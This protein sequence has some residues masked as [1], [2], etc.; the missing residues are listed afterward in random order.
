MAVVE[1]R[2]FKRQ[3]GKDK[4]TG[5]GR[6]T[7]DMQLAGMTHCKFLYAGIANGRI[8]RLDTSKAEALAGVFA[9]VTHAD[10]PDLH[11]GPYIQD[12][13]LFA[14][15]WVRFEGEIIAA[16]AATTPAVAQAA[17]DLIEVDIEPLPVMNDIEDSA[18]PDA[19]LVHPDWESYG[20]SYDIVR[21]R[22]DA[23]RSTLVFGDIDKG[24]A[25]ADTIISGRYVADMQHAAPIEPR[26]IIAEWHGDQVTIWS[27]TQVPFNARAGVAHTLEMPENAVRVIVPHLGGGFGGKCEFHFEAHVAAVARKAKRPTK[28]VFSRREEFIA[29]DHRREGMVITLETGVKR[30]G[31]ITGRRGTLLIDNGA[32]TA[33]GGFFPQLAA[34]HAAGPYRIPSCDIEARIVYTN[35]QPSGSV[36]APTAPQVNWALEQHMDVIAKSLGMDPLELRR[37]NIVQDGDATVSGQILDPHGAPLCLNTAAE[38]VGYGKD[39]PEDEAIGMAIGWWPSFGSSSG[40]YIK[41]NGDG[42]ATIVT[43]AM[44]CGSGAVMA[45]PRLAADVL[46]MQPENF[47]IVYQD[48]EAGPYDMGASGSQTTF[49]NGRAVVAAANV[50]KNRLFEMASERLEA[51]VGDLEVADGL[52]RVKGSPDKSVSIVDLAGEATGGDQLLATGSGDAPSAPEV[53]GSACVGRMGMESWVAPTFFCHAAHVKVDRETGV[54]RVLGI[55]AVHDSGTIINPLG[56]EGQIE[57]GVVMGIGQALLEGSKISDDG[58]ILNAGLLEYKLQTAADVPPIQV[59]FVGPPATDGGPSGVKGIAEPP[60]VPTLA[61]IGNAIAQ[62]IGTHVHELP[63]TPNRVWDT[64][65][66]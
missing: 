5:L 30:D 33:D 62:V 34:M 57:G 22:N 20:D 2:T 29:P 46:G 26:A 36:R 18:A 9:V 3:D 42:S 58:L 48:T 10:V 28:L 65:N 27:S 41:F 17:L 50:I 6:Y 14:R 49:N 63:M 13:R 53:E 15:E 60:C 7:A 51:A 54:V 12:R 39:L 37:K 8:T 35:H 40:A 19:A 56:A 45:L 1:S 4:V 23:G 16:V 64:I 25:E 43:G 21:D 38:L 52:V 55:A 59:A 47:S 66:S 61:A 31:T 11:H 24:M 32:Y 44:E